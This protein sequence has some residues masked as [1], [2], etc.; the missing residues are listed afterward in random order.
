MMADQFFWA[1]QMHHLGVAAEPVHLRRFTATAVERALALACQS[2]SLAAAA[3]DL[4]ITVRTEPDGALEAARIILAHY[5]GTKL[6]PG[7]APT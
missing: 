2:E 6:P 4:A 1:D 5:F 7:D 3:R